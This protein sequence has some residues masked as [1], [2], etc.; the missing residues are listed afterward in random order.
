VALGEGGQANHIRKSPDDA[1]EPLDS[2]NLVAANSVWPFFGVIEKTMYVFVNNGVGMALTPGK[3]T[4]WQ[5]VASMKTTGNRGC[6]AVVDGK[7]YAI[8]GSRTNRKMVDVYTAQT[9]SWEVG[10]AP[11][12]PNNQFGA[13]FVCLFVWWGE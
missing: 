9:D 3:S 4:T 6:T 11:D 5:R 1:W 13:S 7:L 2:T 8:G 12:V 10:G